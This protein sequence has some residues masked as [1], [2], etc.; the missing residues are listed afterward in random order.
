VGIADLIEVTCQ[1]K[2]IIGAD[3]DVADGGTPRNQVTLSSNN[4]GAGCGWIRLAE[5]GKA[6]ITV[7]LAGGRSMSQ[8][9]LENTPKPAEKVFASLS[10]KKDVATSP[11]VITV[12][13]E[14]LGAYK[15]GQCKLVASS[16]VI[17]TLVG[18]GEICNGATEGNFR[19]KTGEPCRIKVT[20][21]AG[22]PVVTLRVEAETDPAVKSGNETIKP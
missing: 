14:F 9:T 10:I 20:L 3:C 7:A 2:K 21:P 12:N 15:V 1:G 4:E 22:S 19:V 5:T 18:G 11:V 6:T 16:N 8:F 13:P 17:A